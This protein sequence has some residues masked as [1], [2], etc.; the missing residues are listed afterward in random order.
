M[1]S[2]ERPIDHWNPMDSCEDIRILR[3]VVNGLVEETRK[4]PMVI[5]CQFLLALTA[6]CVKL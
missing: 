4:L 2:L 6:T 1:T 3:L 5:V